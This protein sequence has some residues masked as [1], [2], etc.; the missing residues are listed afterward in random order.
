MSK[1]K[2]S[3]QEKKILDKFENDELVRTSNFKQDEDMIKSAA[4][5]FL[6]KSQKINIRMRPQDIDLIKSIAVQ[7]GMPYQT[8]ISSVLH[9]YAVSYKSN[10]SIKN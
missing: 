8:L 9:K 7:E 6:K 5:N 10:E 2:L 4:V 1:Y 3:A